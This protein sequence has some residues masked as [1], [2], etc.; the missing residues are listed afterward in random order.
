MR[1]GVRT[2][3]DIDN[4]SGS[5]FCLHLERRFVFHSRQFYLRGKRSTVFLR[6]YLHDQVF[7]KL[8]LPAG[9]RV[10]G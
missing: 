3:D 5:S 6:Y 2:A 10:S 7:R 4:A 8:G 1:N 9:L